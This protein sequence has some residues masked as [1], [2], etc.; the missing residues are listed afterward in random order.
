MICVYHRT[1][2]VCRFFYFAVSLMFIFIIDGDKSVKI[3][4]KR[5]KTC[6]SFDKRNANS[7]CTCVWDKHESKHREGKY[8]VWPKRDTVTLINTGF[9]RLDISMSIDKRS[10]LFLT[11]SFFPVSLLLRLRLILINFFCSLESF[12]FFFFL[13][14][15]PVVY[16]LR[17]SFSSPTFVAATT[18]SPFECISI[19]QTPKCVWI[20]RN[21]TSTR[22]KCGMTFTEQRTVN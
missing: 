6:Y 9:A 3:S 20:H 15:S 14:Y 21:S 17:S 11:D 8:T 5:P 7:H 16:P 4:E 13:L 10:C 18:A 19:T 1:T 12:C 2:H 22:C